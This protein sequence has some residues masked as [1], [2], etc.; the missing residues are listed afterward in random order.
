M[1]ESIRYLH[2][3]DG[4][5]EAVQIP[6]KLWRRLEPLIKGLPQE[7]KSGTADNEGFQEFLDAWTFPYAYDP[8]VTCPHCHSQSNDWRSDPERPFLLTSANISGHLVFHCNK[9]GCTIRHKYF[10][11][12]MAK[13]FTAPASCDQDASE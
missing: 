13:E 1:P 10:R 8:A 9:C 2:S 3:S 6:A 12:H 11:D 5:L 7:T 4:K